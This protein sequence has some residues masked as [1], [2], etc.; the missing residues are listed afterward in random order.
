MKMNLRGP[1]LALAV[2]ISFFAHSAN[3][4]FEVI[5]DAAD[6][7]ELN[8][9]IDEAEIEIDDVN[10][11]RGSAKRLIKLQG[12]AYSDRP[13][14]PAIETSL[15]VERTRVFLKSGEHIYAVLVLGTRFGGSGY[16]QTL[17]AYRI[18]PRPAREIQ[19]WKTFAD[20]EPVMSLKF[21]AGQIVVEKMK[22]AKEDAACCA[23]G[24]EIL[25]LK[26]SPPSQ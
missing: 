5:T 9:T 21:E 18:K 11:E 7:K 26:F 17:K 2:S 15:T 1:L 22:H 8:K 23:S 20:R 24:T 6:L 10:G 3:P 19:G 13:E 14:P 25:K 4:K 12:G 16:F